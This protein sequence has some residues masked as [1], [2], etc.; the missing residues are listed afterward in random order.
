M[1]ILPY[2][3]LVSVVLFGCFA[4]G[5]SSNEVTE[6]HS[7]GSV[8]K[9]SSSESSSEDRDSHAHYSF[10]GEEQ[11][12][13]SSDIQKVKESRSDFDTES[14]GDAIEANSASSSTV[15]TVTGS[16]TT[17]EDP[18]INSSSSGTLSSSGEHSIEEC[19]DG[20]DN[21]FDNLVDCDDTDC[22]I[23]SDCGEHTLE[24]CQNGL[25]DDGDGY[26]DCAD[27]DCKIFEE[28]DGIDESKFMPGNS[29]LGSGGAGGG[30]CFGS[31][32]PTGMFK[33]ASNTTEVAGC[34]CDYTL[35]ETYSLTLHYYDSSHSDFGI[36]DSLG[37]VTGMVSE[38][39]NKFVGEP[40]F[41]EDKQQNMHIGEWWRKSPYESQKVPVSIKMD[42]Y[43]GTID[44]NPLAISENAPTEYYVGDLRYAINK[45]DF[46]P[47]LTF[48][49]S[50]DM[51]VFFNQDL[52]A[53]LGGSGE[54][55]EITLNIHELKNNYTMSYAEYNEIRIFFAKRSSAPLR[56]KIDIPAPC[57]RW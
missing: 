3:L 29:G 40:E 52:I 32:A 37:K 54:Y 20:I 7:H 53:D 22:F 8:V 13:E 23:F 33:V 21:D 45:D 41:N 16:V 30:G 19:L 11:Q 18:Q 56:M 12:S 17:T 25:D 28:C 6:T 51:F 10:E 38:Q 36:P 50:G 55:S 5:T 27:R 49:S 42:T 26:A 43:F 44:E 48:G 47:E 9:E 1:K 14:N 34:F 15:D 46:Y 39:I 57:I 31:T 35:P 2:L 24:L 4:T